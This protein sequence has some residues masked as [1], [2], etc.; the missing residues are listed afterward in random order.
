[1]DDD[2]VID[3]LSRLIAIC[4]DGAS[5]YRSAAES[6]ADLHSQALFMDMADKRSLSATALADLVSSR[7]AEPACGRHPRA[8]AEPVAISGDR[9][10]LVERLRQTEARALD[11]FS[12]ALAQDLPIDVRALVDQRYRA[13]HRAYDRLVMLPSAPVAPG[14]DRPAGDTLAPGQ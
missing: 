13:I 14:H 1:M 9:A 12:K 11:E 3:V 10:A 6:L 8:A 4:R 5:L 7:G 2:S